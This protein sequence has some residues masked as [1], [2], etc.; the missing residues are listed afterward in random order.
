MDKNVTTMTVADLLEILILV[1]DK[2][3][4]VIVPT[5]TGFISACMAHTGLAKDAIDQDVFVIL[6]CHCGFE[7]DDDEPMTD[8]SYFSTN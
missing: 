5:E 2:N 6:P 4:D 1:E 7:D 3:I 8:I